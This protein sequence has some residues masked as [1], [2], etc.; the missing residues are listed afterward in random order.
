M[1]RSTCN[2]DGE[3]G[4]E[5]GLKRGNKSQ[6]D[7]SIGHGRSLSC[8]CQLALRR[9]WVRELTETRLAIVAVLIAVL[10]RANGCNGVPVG[11][12]TKSWVPGIGLDTRRL[13]LR[14]V[15]PLLILGNAGR[16][17]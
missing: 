12:V 13:V 8:F 10:L 14:C 11:P 5:S 3:A 4:I 17:Q 2:G 16:G 1:V 15:E 6:C 9:G 7:A